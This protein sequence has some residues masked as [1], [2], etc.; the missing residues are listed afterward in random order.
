MNRFV[1]LHVG[2]YRYLKIELPKQK[3][4]KEFIKFSLTVIKAYFKELF[5]LFKSLF[6]I[7][8]KEYRKKQ[9]EFKKTQ[10][11]RTDL[12]RAVRMLKYVDQKLIKLGK[13]RQERRQFWRDFYKSAQVRTDVINELEKEI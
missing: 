11:I 10:Q 1:K 9:K 3:T 5:K 7:F 8:D 6:L 12:N 2:L 13:T 4:F